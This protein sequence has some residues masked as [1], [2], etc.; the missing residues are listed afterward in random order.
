M[1]TTEL[2]CTALDLSLALQEADIDSKEYAVI[3]ALLEEIRR[4]IK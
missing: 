2:T 1:Q 3:E 4:E